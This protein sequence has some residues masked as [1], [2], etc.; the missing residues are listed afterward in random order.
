M[1]NNVK[2]ISLLSFNYHVLTSSCE[3][4]GHGVYNNV[5]IIFVEVAEEDAFLDKT[6]DGILCFRA[7]GDDIR[8]KVSLLV[9]LSENLGA[10]PLPTVLLVNLLFLLGLEF[11]QELSFLFLVFFL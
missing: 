8:Y 4:L 6:S 1:L 3:N 7:L 10:D 2:S 11:A 9:E 5:N